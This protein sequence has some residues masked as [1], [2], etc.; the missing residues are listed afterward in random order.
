VSWFPLLLFHDG[1]KNHEAHEAPFQKTFRVFLG[2]L[3]D[4]VK[5]VV[6]E[7]VVPME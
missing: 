6:P 7:I 1:T 4:F 2:L 5:I 3:R